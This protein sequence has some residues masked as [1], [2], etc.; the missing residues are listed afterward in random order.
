VSDSREEVFKLVRWLFLLGVIA[1][2]VAFLVGKP[3]H[4][5]TAAE[6]FCKLI[7]NGDCAKL[8]SRGATELDWLRNRWENAAGT[9]ERPAPHAAPGAR[10][11]ERETAPSKPVRAPTPTPVAEPSAA[12]PSAAP[13]DRH[14]VAERQALDRILTQRGSR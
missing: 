12:R 14:T 3:I 10:T 9:G 5:H 2:L 7:D 6:S 11:V 13:L 1:A 4:G 8:A